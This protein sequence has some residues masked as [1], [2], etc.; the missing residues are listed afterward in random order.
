MQREYCSV[1]E[2]LLYRSTSPLENDDTIIIDAINKNSF[3]NIIVNSLKSK[4]I[5]DSVQRSMEPPPHSS[6]VVHKLLAST[7][8]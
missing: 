7:D 3:D 4:E 2:T 5:N 8:W 6:C 1:I